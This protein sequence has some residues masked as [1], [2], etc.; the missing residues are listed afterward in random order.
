MPQ[1]YESDLCCRP[2]KL[3][4]DPRSKKGVDLF[5]IVR[6][7]SDTPKVPLLD[8]QSYRRNI[9]ERPNSEDFQDDPDVPPLMW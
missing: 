1:K 9:E 6:D 2:E 3:E 5:N 7:P 4:V 8:S